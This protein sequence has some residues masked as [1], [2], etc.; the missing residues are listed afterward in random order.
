MQ[1][2]QFPYIQKAVVVGVDDACACRE[3]GP[4]H[5]DTTREVELKLVVSGVGFEI[6]IVGRIVPSRAGC[7]YKRILEVP[8]SKR[9]FDVEMR[10]VLRLAVTSDRRQLARQWR[11]GCWLIRLIKPFYFLFELT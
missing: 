9:R 5:T 1:S 2:F 7:A 6:K 4:S 11:S 3:S 8:G 10:I